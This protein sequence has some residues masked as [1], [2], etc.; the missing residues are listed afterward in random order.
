MLNAY[1]VITDMLKRHDAATLEM[2]SN[3][4]HTIKFQ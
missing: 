1:I 4:C 2:V 3:I